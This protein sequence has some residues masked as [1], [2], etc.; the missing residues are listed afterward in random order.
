M[1]LLTNHRSGF[2]PGLTK[3]T[4][5]DDP[6][7]IGFSVQK[8]VAGQTVREKA[9]RETAWLLLSGALKANGI[10]LTRRSLFDDSPAALHVS[11]GTD[12]ELA[13]QESVELLVFSTSNSKP[14]RPKHYTQVK[15]EHRGKG[16]V[17]DA[18]Y[19]LVRYLFRRHPHEAGKTAHVDVGFVLKLGARETRAHAQH[20]DTRTAQ[21]L[22]DRLGEADDERLG[23][24][25]GRHVR[26]GSEAADR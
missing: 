6:S 8:L 14:F 19:R 5:L 7:G 23:G 22:G 20:L 25:V 26:S 1:S 21:L 2:G 18:A 12:I 4:G 13:A 9:S 3:V 10:E 24:A 17:H 11:A 16:K 15:D